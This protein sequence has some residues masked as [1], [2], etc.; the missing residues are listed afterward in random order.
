MS[1]ST[2]TSEPYVRVDTEAGS[3][4]Y[5]ARRVLYGMASLLL[6]ALIA[7]VVAD[8]VRVVD[9]FGVDTEHARAE[10]G[11]YELDVRY[12]TVSRPG[13]ATPFDITIRRPGGFDEG[14]VV[15][16]VDAE[17]LS[18][19]DE[20]GLDPTPSAA[21]A[22]DT[23]IIWEFDTPPTGETLVISYDA[24]IEPA[25]QRGKVGR[26]AILDAAHQEQLSVTFKTRVSP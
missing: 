9:I 13:L 11:G 10:G 17:Y 5:K 23:S 20:N 1:P 14:V 24:R 26:V 7:V 15:V 2:A 25:A 19:W 21:T 12:G 6:G 8:G 22:D 4:V 18:I 3:H 16:A